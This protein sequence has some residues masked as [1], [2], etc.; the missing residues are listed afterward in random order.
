MYSSN[1]NETF[2]IGRELGKSIQKPCVIWLYG[3]IGAGKTVFVR[4]FAEGLEVHSRITSPTYTLVH[5]HLGRL[6]LFHFD[7]YRL[8]SD[9]ELFEIGFD[10]YA[11]RGVC[12][13]E[14]AQK[15]TYSPK[16]I[17]VTITKTEEGRCI[18]I[19]RTGY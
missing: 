15:L 4:G 12:I 8:G 5:E 9:E 14:W 17:Y 18:D 10:E 16:G 19:D 3:D 11:D 1:E 13:V 2:E 6:P 7:I